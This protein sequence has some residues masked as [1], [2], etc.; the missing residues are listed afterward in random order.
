MNRQQEVQARLSITNNV[1][2]AIKAVEAV[3]GELSQTERDQLEKT[4]YEQ[5]VALSKVMVECNLGGRSKKVLKL[6]EALNSCN[7]R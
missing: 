2:A 4:M 5:T 1:K 6:V 7:S 3:K